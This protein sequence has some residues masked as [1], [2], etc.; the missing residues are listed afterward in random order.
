MRLFKQEGEVTSIANADQAASQVLDMAMRAANQGTFAVGGLIVNNKTGEVIYKMHNNVMM[1]LSNGHPFTWDPT[2]H[3]ER[4]LVDWYYENRQA[5]NLPPPSELTVIT[6]LDPCVMCTGALLTAGFNV[7]VMAIDDYAGIN[8]DSHFEFQDLPPNLREKAKASFGYYAAGRKGVDPDMYVRDYQ[9]SQSVAFCQDMVT[10]ANLMS[11]GAVF[12]DSS[13]TIRTISSTE[14]GKAPKDLKNPALLP[15]DSPIKQKYREIYP[16]AFKLSAENS[17]I[18]GANILEELKAVAASGTEGDG[19]AVGFL[20]PFGNLVLCLPGHEKM[21][22]IRTPF[23]EV[24]REYAKIRWGLMNDES[25]RAEAENYLSV[26]KYGTF[27]FLYAPEPNAPVGI[28]TLGAYG[29]TMEG[30]VPQVFPTNLQY[31]VGPRS[32][33]TLELTQVICNLPPLY[34]ELVQIAI[35]PSPAIAQEAFMTESF[36]AAA[37]MASV[38]AQTPSR[39]HR[40]ARHRLVYL[41]MFRNSLG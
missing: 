2:A 13:N 22:P 1:K 15:D 27:V 33:S 11:C 9:G 40:H 32:G 26:P 34:T 35:A 39:S 38:A 37:H 16:N 8:Y 23:M 10:S 25:T 6:S 29:S 28:M 7:G 19:N 30:P 14:S 17:R 12:T 41:N 18:P 21:S 24:T 20:D 36:M 31:V 5:L 3:G 4:Q